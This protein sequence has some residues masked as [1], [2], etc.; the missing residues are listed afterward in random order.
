LIDALARN[1][2]FALLSYHEELQSAV[3]SSVASWISLAQSAALGAYILED[4]AVLSKESGPHVEDGSEVLEG[5]YAH[6]RSIS[7]SRLHYIEE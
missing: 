3:A 1:I 7:V 6:G 2:R 4:G 5:M